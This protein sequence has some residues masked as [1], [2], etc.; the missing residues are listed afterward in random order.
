MI[1]MVQ[2]H[3][4]VT[5]PKSSPIQERNPENLKVSK[6]GFIKHRKWDI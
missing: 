1:W 6:F 5:I 2:S 4:Q 3:L